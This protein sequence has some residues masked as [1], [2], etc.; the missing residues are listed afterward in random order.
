[1]KRYYIVFCMVGN[2]LGDY[3]TGSDAKDAYK[4]AFS[5]FRK[6]NKKTGKNPYI[7]NIEIQ[8]VPAWF[9]IEF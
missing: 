9:E 3:F 2:R 5:A 6:Y 4:K 7:T 1:M 8:N